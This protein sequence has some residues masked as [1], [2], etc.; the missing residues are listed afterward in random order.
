MRLSLAC[1]TI[2]AS[3]LAAQQPVAGAFFYMRGSDTV[4]I[5]RFARSA[6]SLVGELVQGGQAIRYRLALRRDGWPEH[7]DFTADGYPVRSG[8]LA[9]SARSVDGE[10]L[11]NGITGPAKLST[12]SLTIPL[13]VPSMA[14][15]EQAVRAIGIADVRV[16]RVPIVR[17]V[18]AGLTTDTV[19]IRRIAPDSLIIELTEGDL[20]V[21][22]ARDGAIV[23]GSGFGPAERVLRGAAPSAWPP[24]FSGRDAGSS[25]RIVSPEVHADRTVTLRLRAPQAKLVTVNGLDEFAFDR[26]L[27]QD[28]T[29]VW[30]LTVGPLPPEVYSYRFTVDGVDMPDPLNATTTGTRFSLVEVPGDIAPWSVRDVPH[31]TVGTVWY[32]SHSLGGA[33]RAVNVYTPPGYERSTDTLPV[34]Y[35]LHG[36]GGTESDLLTD[37]RVNLI[38]DN[39]LSEHKTRRMIVVTPFGEPRQSTKLGLASKPASGG[40]VADDLLQDVIPMIEERYRADRRP[41][42]R[43]I[44]GGS[45]GGSQ[46]LFDLGLA[47]PEMFHWIGG[48][49]SGFTYRPGG[50]VDRYVSA[51]DVTRL[52]SQ[53]RLVWM[54]ASRD[55]AFFAPNQNL[56]TALKARGLTHTFVVVPG[57]HVTS[58]Q[59]GFVQFAQVVFR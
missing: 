20:R 11:R 38:L 27:R 12:A 59:A 35:L 33:F 52:N 23:G 5:E 40:S 21:A 48:F 41:D 45:Q 18:T 31:G 36:L 25:A 54:S 53:L 28:S 34:V 17:P 50:A 39:L 2:L 16:S 55:E 8:S 4:A 37:G 3:S 22:V 56:S 14:L 42:A 10:R 47:H 13:F 49:S 30:T 43:A 1:A 26:R 46:A 58:G 15:L 6:D 32:H 24:K 9:I 44:A 57:F 19:V 7:L 51:L 29:G